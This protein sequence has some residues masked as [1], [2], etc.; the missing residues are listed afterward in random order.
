MNVT[1]KQAPAEFVQKV[2]DRMDTQNLGVSQLARILHVSHPTVTELVTYGKRPSFD[3]CMALAIWL[4]QSPILTLREAG[5]LPPGLDDEIR[6]EDWKY[7]INQLDPEDDAEMKQIAKLK[8]ERKKQE[9][10]MKALKPR[11]AR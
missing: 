2:K 11:K 6:F 8:I 9:R 4:E 5:L 3:T 1:I 7:L 10:G